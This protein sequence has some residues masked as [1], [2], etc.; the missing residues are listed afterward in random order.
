VGDR[1]FL[2]GPRSLLWPLRGPRYLLRLLGTNCYIL[3]MG[4]RTRKSEKS[5]PN[6]EESMSLKTIHE[7]T[8]ELRIS[9]SSLYRL[10]NSGSGPRVIKVGGRTM[11]PADELVEWVAK[12]PNP[13]ENTPDAA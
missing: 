5:Q 8:Q 4:T 6:R 13:F 2:L 12:R 1:P 3:K 7:A 11:V 10:L 9:R